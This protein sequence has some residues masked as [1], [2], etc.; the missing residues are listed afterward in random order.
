MF[1]RDRGVGTVEVV[2]V[3]V[4]DPKPRQGLVEGLVD[5]LWV[6]PD[7][8]VGLAVSE[9]ELRGKED[10]VALS[11]LL[12]PTSP[13][14]ERSMS[15]AGRL[16]VKRCTILRSGPRCRCRRRQCPRRYSQTRKRRLGSVIK[17]WVSWSLPRRG[18]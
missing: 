8:S 10:L 5:V 14:W 3:D 12:E 6:G 17:G 15:A 18:T 16:R 9:T 2:E 7:D 13:E 4:I 11:S 1:D